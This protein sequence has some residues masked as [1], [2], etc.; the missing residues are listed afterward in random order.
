VVVGGPG[1]VVGV[2]GPVVGVVAVGAAGVGGCG[3]TVLTSRV[4]GVRAT[5][6]AALIVAAGAG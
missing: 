2:R 3:S 6:G 1:V 4:A 5:G